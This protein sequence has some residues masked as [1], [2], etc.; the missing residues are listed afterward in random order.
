MV[1]DRFLMKTDA[2]KQ[3]VHACICI[4]LHV[5]KDITVILISVYKRLIVWVFYVMV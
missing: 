1:E 5:A 2:L 3:I 4:L